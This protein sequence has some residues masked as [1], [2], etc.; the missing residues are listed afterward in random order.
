MKQN[1]PIKHEIKRVKSGV[2]K[3]LVTSFGFSLQTRIRNDKEIEGLKA[4]HEKEV[5][6]ILKSATLIDTKKA[7]IIE[8][9][10]IT[11]PLN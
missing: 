1:I 4:T 11:K 5:F 8:A 6:K 10:N 3:Y 7:D 2:H 9:K